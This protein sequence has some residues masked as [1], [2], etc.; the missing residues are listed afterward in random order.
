VPG[1]DRTVTDAAAEAFLRRVASPARRDPPRLASALAAVDRQAVGTVHGTVAAWRIGAGPAV[2]LV[3][4]FEDDNSV[5]AEMLDALVA[6]DRPAVVLDLPAHGFSEG[7]IGLGFEGADALHA[8]AGALGPVDALVAHS[9]GAGA[10]VL[11]LREGLPV[12]R[13]VLIAPPM[14]SGNRWLRLAEREGVSQEIARRAQAMYEATLDPARRSFVTREVVPTLG[15]E[16]LFVH[17]VDDERTP[18]EDTEAVAAECPNARL[19]RVAGCTHR[20]TARDPAA[21]A[22][23]LDFL[24]SPR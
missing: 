12:D 7:E 18:V 22:G 10:A 1:R 3:H 24:D 8:V 15:A 5:W 16:L 6:R 17:S 4:G 21:I 14:R 19:L 2:L 23:I 9:V 13:A 11:A 20:R